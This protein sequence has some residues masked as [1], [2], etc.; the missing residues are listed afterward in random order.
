VPLLASEGFKAIR[1]VPLQHD[2]SHA[3]DDRA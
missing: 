1:R 3:Y 2:A